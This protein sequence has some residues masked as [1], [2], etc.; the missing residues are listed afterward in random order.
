VPARFSH[1]F[2]WTGPILTIDT[3]C[4]SSCVAIHYV[5]RSILSGEVTAALAGGSNLLSS[6][7]WYENLLGAQFLSPTGQVQAIP[8]SDGIGFVFLKK[9]STAITDGDQ[10]YGVIAG[11]KVYQ[12]IGSTTITVPNANS[13]A[14][15]FWDITKQAR[16]DPARVSVVEAHVTSTP[17]GDPA[18]YALMRYPY[19]LSRGLF[20]HTEGASGVCSLLKV[21]LMMHEEVIPPQVSFRSINPAIKATPQDN[22]EIPTRL[23]PWKPETQIALINNYGAS[24]SNS[25]LVVTEPPASGPGGR[26]LLKGKT[27]PF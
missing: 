9:L 7:E 16:V 14:T 3:A 19:R 21:L 27:F 10:V 4:S 20:G 15:L 5:C 1:P 22:I 23:T 6:V 26:E 25:S 8:R 24:G 2:G 13:L 17:V 12:N 18:E 11:S